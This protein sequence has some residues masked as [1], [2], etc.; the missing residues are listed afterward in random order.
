[1]EVYPVFAKP[2]AKFEYNLTEE[3]QNFLTNAQ[4]RSETEDP[5]YGGVSAN[6]MIM[7]EPILKD[8]R[9]A[10]LSVALEFSRD[11]LGIDTMEMI[12]VCSWITIK[13]P[14]QHHTPHYHP[15]S[16]ISGVYFF[17]DHLENMPLIFE[18]SSVICN[19]FILR[20]KY[21]LNPD[22]P[23]PHNAPRPVPVKKGDV[24]LFPSYLK[25]SVMPNNTPFN[26]YSLAFNILPKEGLGNSGELTRFDYKDV[27]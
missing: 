12:D 27:L 2:I 20:P 5:R 3:I 13:R 1:M 9:E 22:V 25:H 11:L 4:T 23:F 10:V 19:D 21:I 14:G 15:N 17:D 16:V 24:V 6:T 18:E 7:R 8:F 26:R